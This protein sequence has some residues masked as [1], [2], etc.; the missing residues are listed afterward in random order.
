MSV[1]YKQPVL[2]IE[3]EEHKSFSLEAS[4]QTACDASCYLLLFRHLLRSSLTRRPVRNIHKKNRMVLRKPNDKPRLFN[5]NSS[6][7]VSPFHASASSGRLHHSP[8][9]K[10][11]M[12]SNLTIP[13]LIHRRQSLSEQRRTLT[14]V[15]VSTLLQ[16]SCLG[17][18]QASQ[19]RM[20]SM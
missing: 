14:R 7:S 17:A 3:F 20:S 12:T 4:V 13:S 8:L 1:H 15:L 2:L 16:K 19:P 18:C 10:Y 9:L 11:S 5:T 6:S